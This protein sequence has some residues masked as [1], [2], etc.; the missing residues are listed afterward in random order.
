[1]AKGGRNGTK[2]PMYQVLHFERIILDGEIAVGFGWHKQ[3]P[4]L[5]RTE[6]LCEIAPIDFVVADV[7]LLPRPELGKQIVRILRQPKRFLTADQE[8]FERGEAT[9][10]GLIHLLAVEGGAQHPPRIHTRERFEA[11]QR[12][13]RKPSILPQG[14]SSKRCLQPGQE[15]EIV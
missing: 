15:D 12:W 11:A 13:C 5:D 3:R 2:F 7:S 10:K 8:P 6:R 14:I 9:A 1:M 4:R